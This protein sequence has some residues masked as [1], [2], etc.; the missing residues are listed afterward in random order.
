M[1]MVTMHTPMY[2]LNIS[3]IIITTLHIKLNS[4]PETNFPI[5]ITGIKTMGISSRDDMD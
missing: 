2:L 3:T 4:N 5:I 1:G